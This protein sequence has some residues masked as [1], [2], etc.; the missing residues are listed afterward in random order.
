MQHIIEKLNIT[1]EELQRLEELQL[2]AHSIM[3]ECPRC[4][5]SMNVDRE[6]YGEQSVI[7]CP[8]PRCGHKWCKSCLKTVASS[9][10]NHRCKNGN[11]DRL[12]RRK[13]WKYCPG[14][15]TPVQKESGCNHMTCGAPGCNV[16]FCYKCGVLMIDTTNGGDVGT[17]VTE[18]YLNCRLFE[19]KLRCSIQ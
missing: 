6:Q 11:I 17:A 8:L 9:E 18:H 19:K 4:K 12:M 10:E 16:H 5:E 7:V 2:V 14:C 3:L 13:G 1:P 15:R